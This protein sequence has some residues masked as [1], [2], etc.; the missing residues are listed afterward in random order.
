M[1]FMKELLKNQHFLA[2]QFLRTFIIYQN[3]VF[4]FNPKICPDNSQG[5]VPV[6]NDCPTQFVT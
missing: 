5:S 6:F 3:Q 2:F 1:T 4:D